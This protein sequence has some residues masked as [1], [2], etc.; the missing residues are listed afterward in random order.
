[1]GERRAAPAWARWF[2]PSLADCFLVALFVV[3]SSGWQGFL[4]DGDTGWH[5]RTGEWILDHAAVPKVDLFSFSRAGEAWFAWEWL[6]DVL[7]AAL[8]R[9]GGLRAV[10]VLAALCIVA[11]AGLLLKQMLWRGVNPLA[12]LAFTLIAVTSSSIHFLARPHLFTL[13][14][15]AGAMWMIERDRRRAWRG[16]WI[17]PAMTAIWTNVHGGVFL[18]ILLLALLVAGT[19]AEWWAGRRPGRIVG[20]QAV[21]LVGCAA[22]TLVNPY[23]WNLHRHVLTYLN[24]DWIR[25]AVQEFQAPTFRGENQLHFE[26]LLIV[27]LMAAGWKLRRGEFVEA[28]WLLAAAYLALGSAR[29][30]PIYAIVAAPLAAVE[31]DRAWRAWKRRRGASNVVSILRQLG[32]DLRAA[33]GRWSVWLPIG[34]AAALFALQGRLPDRFPSD[35]FPSAMIGRHGAL[36]K[37]SRVLSSDQWGDYLIFRFYPQGKVF[38]DGRSDFYGEAVGGDYLRMRNGDFRWR[39]LLRSYEIQAVLIPV[40]WPLAELLKGDRNWRLVEDDGSTL[41]FALQGTRGSGR[42]EHTREMAQ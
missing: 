9:G 14:L 19:G 30:I 1:M 42:N 8:F 21:L 35:L 2:A 13:A 26:A 29:H 6:S 7:F 5:I 36:L 24:S 3:L 33:F 27:G 34:L 38:V 12:A 20:R 22:A 11:L 10:V 41:L 15:L 31:V 25:S 28:L 32:E 40:S 4:A 17:L 39:R 37:E 16:I 18:L 23:G